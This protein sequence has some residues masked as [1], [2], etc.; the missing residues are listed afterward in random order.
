MYKSICTVIDPDFRLSPKLWHIFK[1]L[2]YVVKNEIVG[3]AG[4]DVGQ[5]ALCGEILEALAELLGVLVAI[6][7]EEVGGQAGDDRAG[8]RCSGGNGLFLS[9]ICSFVDG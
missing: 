7:T 5:D 2:R 8:G 3:S 6:Q 9:V 4:R 1:Q